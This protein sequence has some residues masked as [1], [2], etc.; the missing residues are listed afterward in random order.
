[1]SGIKKLQAGEILFREGDSSDAMY[2]IKSGRIAITKTKG[3]GEIILAEKKK[4]EMLGEMAFFDNKPRSAGAKAVTE[5]EVISLPFTSLYAQFKTFPEWLKA[6]V[7][8]VNG[9]LRDANAR[10]KNLEQAQGA[11][12]EVFPPHLITRL[13]AVISLVGFKSGEE[14]EGGLVVPFSILRNY[15]IQIFQQP[16]NKLEKM[17]EVLSALGHMKVEDLGEGKRRITIVNHKL[18]TAFTDWYNKY[19]FTEEGK[20]ITIIEKELPAIRALIFYG[21]KVEAN[22]KG[23]VQVNL[24]EMQNNSMK[25]LNTLFNTSDADSLAEKGLAEEKQSGEGAT[26]TMKIKLKELEEILPFWEI[27]YTLKKVPGRG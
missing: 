6:V 12:E 2:V 4:G 8:T 9:H 27:I 24:T 1:M 22:D 5:C 7:R 26:L 16:T 25:D 17:M 11:D 3:A 23:E 19:L 18:I 20:R 14:T 21:K 10:I 15:C 13:T